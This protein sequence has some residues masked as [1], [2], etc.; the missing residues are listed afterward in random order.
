MM[1]NLSF[2]EFWDRAHKDPVISAFVKAHFYKSDVNPDTGYVTISY[3]FANKEDA[4]VVIGYTWSPP[5]GG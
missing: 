1:Q 2:D 4:D 5:V 3:T